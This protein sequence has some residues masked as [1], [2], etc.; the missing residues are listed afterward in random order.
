MKINIL[1]TALAALIPVML[2]F[3]WYHPKALGNAWQ[4]AAGL[5]DDQIKNANMPLIFGLSL[6]FALMLSIGLN[7]MVIHQFHLGS[8]LMNEPGFADKSGEAWTEYQRLLSSYGNNFRSFGHGA[9]HG[10]IG[11]LFVVVPALITNALFE[12][13]GLAYGLINSG[14]WILCLALMG[15]VICAFS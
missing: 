4:K 1:I 5:S 11:G 8:L 9:I 15:G 3:I 12:R 10:T 13:K 7:P 6:L 14:Y 2:G